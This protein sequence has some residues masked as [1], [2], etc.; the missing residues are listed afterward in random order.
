MSPLLSKADHT[1]TLV[2]PSMPPPGPAPWCTVF[3]IWH[4]F[5]IFHCPVLPFPLPTRCSVVFDFPP[6]KEKISTLVYVV[7]TLSK[8][9]THV[10]HF[11]HYRNSQKQGGHLLP[12]IFHLLFAPSPTSIWVLPLCGHLLKAALLKVTNVRI[13]VPKIPS[14]PHLLSAVS[15]TVGKF[16]LH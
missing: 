5:P 12:L 2:S 11:I 1:P 15:D 16:L 3:H 4:Y 9:L 8:L 10:V 13:L 7:L 14:D 6:K